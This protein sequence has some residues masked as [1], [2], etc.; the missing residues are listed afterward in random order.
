MGS[1][2]EGAIGGAGAGE[3]SSRVRGW[4]LKALVFIGGA[5]LLK[6]LTKSTTRWDHTRIV[7]DSLVGE[8]V[9]FNC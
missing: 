9:N 4:V 5:I 8:K 2:G 3:G 1:D 6:K 7:A